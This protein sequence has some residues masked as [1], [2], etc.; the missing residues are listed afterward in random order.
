M[1]HPM[2][3]L[4]VGMSLVMFYL[5]LLA[6]SEHIGFNLAWLSASLVCALVNGV[7]LQAVMKGWKRS[8]AF[9]AGLLTLDA[10][11]WQLLRSQESALLLGTAVLLVVLTTMMFL[12]RHID[13]YALSKRAPRLK[14]QITEG[15][16][17]ERLWK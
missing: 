6:L 15:D 9:S 13:W 12:T 17:R 1:M 8:L 10:V 4:L 11:L 3:Y 16:E 14:P 5:V 7:Y 2:Q